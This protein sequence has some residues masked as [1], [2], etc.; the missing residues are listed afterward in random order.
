[1]TRV[2]KTFLPLQRS[3]YSSEIMILESSSHIKLQASL[4]REYTFTSLLTSFLA[5]I[6]AGAIH[7]RHSMI[8]LT[9]YGRLGDAVD[10]CLKVLVEELR[11]EGMYKSNG[12]AVASVIVEA[13][14]EVCSW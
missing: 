5:A 7:F 4:E 1:M 10:Q 13:I 14:R 12:D 6:R 3:I 11:E 9:Y 8:P 2:S